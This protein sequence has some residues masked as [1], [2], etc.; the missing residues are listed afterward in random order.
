MCGDIAHLPGEAP[1]KFFL[2]S[3]IPG[4][5]I[6]ALELLGIT[7]EADTTWDVNDAIARVRSRDRRYTLRQRGDRKKTV[8]RLRS[9]SDQDGVVCPHEFQAFVGID[10]DTIAGAY[11][12]CV[13]R[14]IG[15][16]QT[17]SEELLANSSAA[18]VGNASHPAKLNLVGGAVVEF[19]APV[20]ACG[21]GKILPTH[22]VVERQFGGEIP[23]I[24]R[25]DA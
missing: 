4:L 19:N 20:V 21:C 24:A 11:H 9:E 16:P 22:T 6:A 1:G 17:R 13:P 3:E 25:I 10:G 2:N 18:I 7:R 12:P 5:N 14:T 8:G 23:P 15:H